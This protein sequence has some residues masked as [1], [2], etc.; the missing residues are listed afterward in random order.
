MACLAIVTA[1]LA[2]G[3]AGAGEVRGAIVDREGRLTARAKVWITK[4]FPRA[5]RTRTAL[6]TRNTALRLAGSSRRR[7]A[8]G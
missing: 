1:L 3:R 5:A 4:R 8:T 6:V 7:S 2:L